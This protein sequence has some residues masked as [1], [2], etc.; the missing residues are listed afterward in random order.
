MYSIMY[1]VVVNL[2]MYGLYK[3]KCVHWCKRSEH[4]N[5]RSGRRSG[6]GVQL[7]DEHSHLGR[8]VRAV[9]PLQHLVQ[10]VSEV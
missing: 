2:K 3:A 6:G 10:H 9:V 1:Q 8:A 5:S 4:V 7:L